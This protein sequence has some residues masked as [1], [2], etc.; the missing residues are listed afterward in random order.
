MRFVLRSYVVAVAALCAAA[1]APPEVAEAQAR[2]F[3]IARGG[4]SR[5]TWVSDAPLERVTGTTSAVSGELQVDA[6]N[7]AASRGTVQVDVASFDTGID[8][9]DEHLRGPNWL[10]AGR[11]P[12]ATLEITGVEGATAL[13]P[14]QTI[15]VTIRGRFS[16]HGVT[17][18]VSIPAQIRLLPVDDALRAQGVTGDLLR[19]QASFDIQLADYNVSISAPVR[20][21]VSETIR[22]N[23]TI[24]A[25]AGS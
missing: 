19:A 2:T 11:Y 6:A 10:D 17:R 24:R 13:Q 1:F 12:Q 20:L 25:M 16:L 3:R 14:G 18:D 21:Q 8:L 15:R 5:V 7:L 23:V 9:R 4:G 22:I